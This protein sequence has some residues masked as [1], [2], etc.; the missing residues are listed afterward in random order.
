MRL[1]IIYLF[2]AEY[3]LQLIGENFRK[4]FIYIYIYI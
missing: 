1:I 3:N 4:D 2:P